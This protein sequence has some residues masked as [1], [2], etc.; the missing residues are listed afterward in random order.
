MRLTG[1]LD[2]EA[3]RSAVRDLLLRH[4]PLR[5]VFGVADG[6]PYQRVLAPAE[7]DW[8]VEYAEVGADELTGA[9][10]QAARHAFDLSVE[11]PIRASLFRVDDGTHALLLVLHHIASDGWSRG[12]LS[13][14]LSAA[15]AARLR[16]Q[17][18]GWAPLPVQYADYALW[19]RDLL[20][21]ESNA[22]S[23]L[24]KQVDYWLT[25]LADAPEELS[26]PVDRPRPAVSA[27]RGHR[28]P[29]QVPAE[30]HR[31]LQ[32]VSRAEG[33]TVFMTLQAALAVTL[34]RLGAGTDIPIG[35]AVAGRSDEALNDLIGF[36]INTLVIRTDLS[37]DPEFR[38]VLERVREASLGAMA[39]QD[40]PFERLVEELAP[41]RSLARHPLYQVM[42][43]LHDAE[44]GTLDLPGVTVTGES[45]AGDGTAIPARFDLDVAFVE[46]FDEQGDPA[47]LRGSVTADAG[48]FDEATA[49]RIADWYSRLLNT[50]TAAA[51]LRLHAIDLLDAPQ[52]RQ[53]LTEWND[54]A[55]ELAAGDVAELF[56]AQVAA[57]PDAVAV[58]AGGVSVSYAEVDEAANRL[59]HYLVGQGVGVESVVGLCLPA[60]VD[61]V[62]AILAV[63]KVGAGYVPIDPEYPVERISFML[64][65]SGSVLL[66]TDEGTSGDLPVSGSTRMVV[67]DD[68]LVAMQVAA[69]PVTAP[70]APPIDAAGLAYVIYTSGSTGT[71]KGVAVT[72]GGL[73]NYVSWAVGAY[74]TAA[75]GGAPLHSSIA[76][77]LTVT[78]IVVPL[79]SGS[80]VVVSDLGG[81]EGLA[82]LLRDGGGFGLVKVVPAHLALLSEVLTDE[83]VAGAAGVWVVGGE[84]LPGPLVGSWLERALGSV[85]VNEYGPTETVVG[86][87]V[88]EVT[89]GQEVGASVPIGR[90]IANTRLFVLDEG[91]RPVPPGVAGELYIAGAQVAR[92]YVGRGGLTA[93]RFVACPHGGAGERMY[94]TGDLAKWTADGLLEF[95]GRADE[96]VKIRGYRIEPGEI[97]AVLAAHPAVAQA[98][99]IVREDRL[100]AYVVGEEVPSDRLRDFA[101][102]RLPEYMVPGAVVAL[103]ALPLTTNGKLDR[104]ALPAPEA[105]GGHGRGPASVLEELLCG[106][107]AE[108]LG[109]PSVGVEDN[110]FDLGGD[111]V[112]S[113]RITSMTKTAFDVDLT[114][115]DV[116]ATGTVL[117]LAELIEE[118]VLLE[119]ERLVKGE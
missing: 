76:F 39:H 103:P 73:A 93:E 82:D 25:T 108:V 9:A 49:L 13:R 37:G 2:V 69:A 86:C 52:R 20:G 31:R 42:L 68:P 48:L 67:L 111:S 80:A 79:V 101:A 34:S 27:H 58:R 83:Q 117:A 112:R 38:Q 115:R 15:Y 59:A 53:V 11:I 84:A 14:D 24:S 33:V 65:D 77:D 23:V 88:F 16:G 87:C 106:L 46:T 60:G 43:T 89:A 32:E 18:P 94:R 74:G 102:Q 19:Q 92:G 107:C 50:V 8:D 26:L 85:V 22:D 66:L 44:R 3:I 30:V 81:A 36:F 28:V 35:T 7:L 45:V 56:A 40:V 54:T 57:V 91:L 99:V 78:S 98:A 114:P 119:L 47:G 21:D 72:H 63:W 105:A 29:L 75:G 51:H 90:P 55:V 118:K 64:A 100:V 104:K 41:S 12:P 109:V 4:E 113:L 5:T 71:P 70:V 1:E 110:F 61:L 116:L 17:A 97:E 10:R 95:L 96:Q 62:T 6:E